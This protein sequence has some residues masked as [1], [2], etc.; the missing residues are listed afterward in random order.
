MKKERKNKIYSSPSMATDPAIAPASFTT[1][2]SEPCSGT[3]KSVSSL[4]EPSA[5]ASSPLSLSLS[6]ASEVFVGSDVDVVDEAV[7]VVDDLGD[8]ASAALQ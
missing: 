3:A 5:S 6:S 4:E 2:F 8:C 1:S 7:V